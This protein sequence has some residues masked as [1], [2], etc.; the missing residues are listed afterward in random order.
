MGRDHEPKELSL[1][2]Q[3]RIHG[4]LEQEWGRTLGQYYKTGTKEDYKAA[5]NAFLEV[6]ESE[7]LLLSYPLS[8]QQDY[9]DSLLGRAKH[10]LWDVDLAKEIDV[11]AERVAL[12]T[13]FNK[14]I[15][16]L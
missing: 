9:L 5:S 16:E 3:I 4:G 15:Q 14:T 2:D 8:D 10:D 7:K 6:N 12:L 1:T 11:Q 13:I